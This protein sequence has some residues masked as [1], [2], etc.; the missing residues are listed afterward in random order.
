MAVDCIDHIE[1]RAAAAK[2]AV[3]IVA[4]TTGRL[5]PGAG[6]VAAGVLDK[7]HGWVQNRVVRQR[8]KECLEIFRNVYGIDIPE[9]WLTA[10]DS[11][12]YPLAPSEPVGCG[13][14]HCPI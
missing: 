7:T 1:N 14:R 2:I 8:R 4:T 6:D 12:S 3:S 11:D 5:V 10:L 13:G 9:S